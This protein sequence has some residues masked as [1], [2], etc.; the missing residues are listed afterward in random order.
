[1]PENTTI[2]DLIEKYNVNKEL[3]H[4]ILVNGNYTPFIN[5]NQTILNEGDTLAIWPPVAGG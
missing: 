3:C 4:L 5:A 1:V 2:M